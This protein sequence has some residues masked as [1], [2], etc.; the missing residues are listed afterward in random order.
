M[1][2]RDDLLSLVPHIL[3]ARG[4]RLYTAKG[5][6]VDL[7]Q[8]GGRAI[9]GHNPPLLLRVIKNNAERGI[10]A[11]YPHFA[12]ERFY[13][14]LAV[15]FPGRIFR[16][17]ENNASLF[18]AISAAGLGEVQRLFAHG[19]GT[20][21]GAMLWRPFLNKESQ[22]AL[23]SVPVLVPVLPC[24]FPG[25]PAVLAVDIQKS[26]DVPEKLPP[27]DILSPVTLAAATRCI[28]DM[29]AV[30]SRGTPRFLKTD[31][32]LKNN[33]TWKRQ[34]IYL[35]YKDMIN[36]QDQ[37]AEESLNNYTTLF[38]CFLKAGFL[39]PPSPEEPAVLPGELSP[40]E[41][42]KLTGLFGSV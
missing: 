5:C 35:I 27:S 10:Y 14:A 13:K 9:L 23:L 17:Y 11:P 20:D 33:K 40:G 6:L 37:I 3:R 1:M 22:D 15:L 42:A 26:P 24:P 19:G 21:A 39:L 12:E 34:G 18:K 31:K 2:I 8:Y 41:E 38:T 25:A 30:P 16:I 32:A 28:Y 29:L 7:W 36:E 4:W